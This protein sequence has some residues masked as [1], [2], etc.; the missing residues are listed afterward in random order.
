M[1][2][3]M[4]DAGC[5]TIAQ[6]KGI[7]SNTPKE[8]VLS[9]CVQKGDRHCMKKDHVTPEGKN[10]MVVMI[11]AKHKKHECLIV[12]GGVPLV[13]EG[14]PRCTKWSTIEEGGL[15]RNTKVTK[16]YAAQTYYHER[17]STVDY[18]NNVCIH[19]LAIWEVWPTSDWVTR[20]Y[21]GLFGMATG[22]F[23]F[24]CK[25][26][27]VVVRKLPTLSQ[28]GIWHWHYSHGAGLKNI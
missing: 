17:F 22:N 10:V 27:R 28:G 4:R 12:S 16:R 23:H 9:K 19:P 6:C 25:N 7:F 15:V 20:D 21:A 3:G 26:L 13:A 24:L 1:T 2:L 8:V 5:Y 14:K 18:F 11:G